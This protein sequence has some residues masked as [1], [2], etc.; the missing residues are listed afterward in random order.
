MAA[1]IVAQSTD[2]EDT[3]DDPYEGRTSGR[4]GG[5]KGKG[6]PRS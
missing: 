5:K 3:G 1:A 2:P 6:E 4:P